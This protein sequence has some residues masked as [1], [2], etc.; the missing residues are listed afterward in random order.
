MHLSNLNSI[1][2]TV[3]MAIVTAKASPFLDL[4]TR[5]FGGLLARDLSGNSCAAFVYG[6]KNT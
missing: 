6:T 4:D 3:A 5:S 1:L 2:L